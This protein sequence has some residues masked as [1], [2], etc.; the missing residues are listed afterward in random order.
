M[1]LNERLIRPLRELLSRRTPAQRY[2]LLGG[3]AAVVAALL[4]V[5]VLAGR[6]PWETV[7]PAE[8]GAAAVVLDGLRRG[9]F[10]ARSTASGIQVTA[11]RAS[12]A[13]LRIAA[14][15]GFDPQTPGCDE[16]GS[17]LTAPPAVLA[18]RLIR[19]RESALSQLVSEMRPL[20]WGRV[21]LAMPKE[22]PFI[23]DSRPAKA[24]VVVK[25]RE[26][27]ALTDG[28]VRAIQVQ[29]AGAVEGLN[30]EQVGVTDV[31]MRL[32]T[33]PPQGSEIA[34]VSDLMEARTALEAALREKAR[35]IVETRFGI[36]RNVVQV[37][38]ELDPASEEVRESDLRADGAVPVT[39]R[40]VE[41]ID[42]RGG[43]SDGGVPGAT[44][45]LPGGVG[46]TS[47]SSGAAS[48]RV[49]EQRTNEVPRTLRRTERPAGGL[50]RITVAVLVSGEWTGEGDKKAY[51]APPDDD[52][53]K[54]EKLVKAAVGFDAARGD[55]VT[56]E[57]APFAEVA[58]P[59]PVTARSAL[60]RVPWS[61]VLPY[62]AGALLLVAAWAAL[63]RP[64]TRALGEPGGAG[65]GS[66]TALAGPAG[67]ALAAAS[68]GGEEGR[69]PV[70]TFQDRLRLLTE[71]SAEANRDELSRLLLEDVGHTVATLR[72]WIADETVPRS[73][74]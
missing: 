23:E 46:A 35:E 69:G 31:A 48:S 1:D 15:T 39:E 26:G 7:Y 8:G 40:L 20:E 13:R 17:S 62:G 47:T 16:E 61:R 63:V 67:G 55:Q 45:N 52:L 29:V 59:A 66:T 2:A 56:V 34:A 51:A 50:K 70:P 33:K 53:R 21:K 11:D 27:Y 49:E 9:G 58:A 73:R 3:V 10:E 38:V 24:S 42:S 74:D 65:A 57:H 25:P 32:Y 44:A 6:T 68:A 64:V 28:M 19:C 43:A 71:G 18:E 36:G 30:P 41:D 12:E 22:S 14:G 54:I 4:G 37:N 72:N 5:V 60:D